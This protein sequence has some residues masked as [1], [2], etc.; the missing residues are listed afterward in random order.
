MVNCEVCD[1]D[2]L[3]LVNPLPDGRRK[4]KC[5]RCGHS[6]IRGE[7]TVSHVVNSAPRVDISKLPIQNP[8]WGLAQRCIR[9]SIPEK[10]RLRTFSENEPFSVDRIDDDKVILLLA[11]RHRTPIPW[12]VWEATVKFIASRGTI[13]V[14][15]GYTVDGEPGTLDGFLKQHVNRAV[16]GW[17]AV[18]L[19]EAGLVHLNRNR[20]ATVKLTDQA[21]LL[22]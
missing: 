16:S 12:D 18:V 2:D 1:S 14:G 3:E 5:L 17:V 8:S 13:R 21:K 19:E 7:P 20:P 15:G 6:W 11:Q 4:L 10:R 22:S 9:E